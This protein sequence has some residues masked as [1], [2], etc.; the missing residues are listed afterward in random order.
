M[1]PFFMKEYGRKHLYGK[2]MG[3]YLYT[4]NPNKFIV[5]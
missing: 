5:L 3:T 2:N 1:P 4:A